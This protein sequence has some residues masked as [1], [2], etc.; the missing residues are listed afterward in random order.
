[1]L[2][3]VVLQIIVI[4]SVSYHCIINS[5]PPMESK[6]IINYNTMFIYGWNHLLCNNFW[7]LGWKIFKLWVNIQMFHCVIYIFIFIVLVIFILLLLLKYFWVPIY[8]ICLSNSI[9]IVMKG[10]AIQYTKGSNKY[11]FIS[12]TVL[13][14][15]Y[16][17]L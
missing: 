9:I 4:L 11:L 12:G 16:L 14:S 2:L 5:L 6:L 1:M 15:V 13:L 10:L 17:K 8:Y 7:N 3:V